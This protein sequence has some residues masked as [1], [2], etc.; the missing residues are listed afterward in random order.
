MS[1]TGVK[2]NTNDIDKEFIFS[3]EVECFYQ[4]LVIGTGFDK[5]RDIFVE[6]GMLEWLKAFNIN[7]LCMA[8]PEQSFK[9]KPTEDASQNELIILFANMMEENYAIL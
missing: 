6:R 8:V 9:F 7:Q 1:D 2:K 4:T 5:K 3:R